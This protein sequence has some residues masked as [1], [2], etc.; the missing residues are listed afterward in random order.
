MESFRL[1]PTDSQ[2]T[3]GKINNF[4]I[5]GQGQTQDSAFAKQLGAIV[6]NAETYQMPGQSLYQC[7]FEPGV[8]FRVWNQKR[9]V[10]TII[11]FSCDQLAV[12]EHDP[13]IPM[14]TL[15]GSLQGRFVVAGDFVARPQ[16]LKLARQA[17]PNQSFRE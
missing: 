6:L 10:D 12:V 3:L 11:C 4:P 15:G 16:L 13:E 17:F 7:Y 2:R 1:S 8:A 9:F 14:N 5:Y